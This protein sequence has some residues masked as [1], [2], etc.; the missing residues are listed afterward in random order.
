MLNEQKRKLA[1]EL[2]QKA[3]AWAGTP[4]GQKELQEAGRRA[5]ETMR[6]Y[7][8]AIKVPWK[9]LYEPFTI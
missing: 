3:I 1:Q 9:K 5:E 4:E 2:A 7:R 6:Q 8:E